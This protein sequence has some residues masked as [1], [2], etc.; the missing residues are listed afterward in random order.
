MPA[1]LDGLLDG[2][3]QLLNSEQLD[4]SL[5]IAKASLYWLGGNP[6]RLGEAFPEMDAGIAGSEWP[7][8]VES[9]AVLT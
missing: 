9:T 3:V 6:E 2:G 7:P 4:Y 8:G 5:R 1:E